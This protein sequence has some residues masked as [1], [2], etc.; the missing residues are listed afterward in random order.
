MMSVEWPW[1]VFMGLLLTT[2][3]PSD[4]L[5]PGGSPAPPDAAVTQAG[6]TDCLSY[7][8]QEGTDSYGNPTL[9]VTC[10]L[11]GGA[12]GF[13]TGG[14]GGGGGG[15]VA[16]PGGGGGGSSAPGVPLTPA[17]AQ[18]VN[19][20]VDAAVTKLANPQCAALFSPYASPFNSGS[21]V[22]QEWLLGYRTGDG[23]ADCSGNTAAH[24]SISQSPSD[25]VYHS[26]W[27]VIC[28]GF[29]HLSA[30]ERANRIL[31]EALHVAGHREIPPDSTGKTSSQI[32]QMVRGACGS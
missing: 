24:T 5:R 11:G 15:G 1:V 31:H 14:G 21:F 18:L 20:A 26:R 9:A 19:P 12:I 6:P 10:R 28:T 30:G 16:N 7:N 22:L 32:D 23:T 13:P 4:G 2:S 27:V 17:Q 3:S 8:Y 25:P 29:S